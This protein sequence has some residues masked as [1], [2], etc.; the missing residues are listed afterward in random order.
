M[1]LLSFKSYALLLIGGAL[2]LSHPAAGQAAAGQATAGQATAGQATA[3]WAPADTLRA[4]FAQPPVV[5]RP[6]PAPAPAPVPRRS[7][8]A[9]VFEVEYSGFPAEA[10]AAFQRAVD[11]WSE[12]VESAVPIR[13]LAE[14]KP[15]D[16]T[17]ILGLAAPR[18]I[19]NFELSPQANTW[20]V[21]AL[22]DALA[23]RDQDPA[24]ADI[25]AEFNSEFPSWYFGLDAAPPSGQF[26]LVTVA[27]HELGHG[28]G[29]VGSMTVNGSLGSWG[30]GDQGYPVI[31][32]RFTER[33]DG[34]DLLSLPNPS[35]TLA[36]A[37]TDEV[38]FDGPTARAQGSRPTLFAPA[39]WQGGSSYSHLDE[40]T[41]PV[42]TA[43]ALMT[44]NFARGEA[45][46]DPGPL[47]CGALRD[48]GWVLTPVCSVKVPLEDVL[49]ER[50]LAF[51]AT[52][53]AD[54]V[55]LTFN[56]PDSTGLTSGTLEREAGDTFVPV[57]GADFPALDPDEAGRYTVRVR[58][59]GPGRY[60]FRLRLQSENG[61][62]FLSP[63]VSI[64]LEPFSVFP[65]PFI[66]ESTVQ[67]LLAEPQ[68]GS[69][70]VYD[71]HGRLVLTLREND[72]LTSGAIP[73][74]G[75]RLAAGVYF[76]R[77]EGE[78]FSETRIVTLLR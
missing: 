59:L 45:V 16:E 66:G 10:Q 25:R 27:L 64:V 21:S 58:D 33:G 31:Y 76:V 56:L 7:A 69:V 8:A 36:D 5:S 14:W 9:A 44:P 20:Y 11:L 6:A 41:Y 53:E 57:A 72:E 29:F 3:A 71:A 13:V 12:R 34:T 19:A 73:L 23:G 47:T 18:V 75:R 50:V 60:G 43:N 70:R 38:F 62:S 77:V 24:N 40:R 17:D 26:D 39:P 37:L 61:T 42:G 32:D 49:T 67:L 63:L 68:A 22:A 46:H 15:A 28:L 30:L 74:D 4:D 48:I 52:V 78:D 54:E 1:P 65:N 55:V 35:G 51:S 2:A